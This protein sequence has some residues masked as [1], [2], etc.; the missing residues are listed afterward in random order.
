MEG[1]CGPGAI[2]G[3]SDW[4][5]CFVKEDNGCPHGFIMVNDGYCTG[6]DGLERVCCLI[7]P[8]IQIEVKTIVVLQTDN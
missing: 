3:Q 2:G 7:V 1:F 6:D 5:A 8:R 4:F